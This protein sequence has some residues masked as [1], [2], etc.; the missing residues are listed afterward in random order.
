MEVERQ[1][2]S[3]QDFVKAPSL[4]EYLARSVPK[5]IHIT[6]E[7]ILA[8]SVPKKI[9]ISQ[10][11]HHWRLNLTFARSVPI[12]IYITQPNIVIFPHV[13]RL[14]QRPKTAIQVP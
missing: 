2:P 13:S 7:I 6:Q 10:R 14:L 9:Y 1:D 4:A 11:A 3:C 5:N 12:I 8:R